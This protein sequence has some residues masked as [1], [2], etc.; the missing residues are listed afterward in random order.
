MNKRNLL[1]ATLGIGLAATSAL[2]ER[3]NMT[4]NASVEASVN[5][6]TQAVDKAG[7][8]VFAVVN[9]SEGSASVGT[10]LR[11][12]TVVIFGSPTIGAAALQTSQTL[13]LYLPLR[14]LFFEDA[15]GQTWL[16]YEDP[17]H[18]AP[19]HG[20]PADNPAVQ[21]MQGALAKF[22]AVAAGG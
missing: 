19:T 4:S 15:L 20:V 14:I 22:A 13:A 18:V 7:A 12:T 9:F 3:I 16:T 1:A 6:L 2:A 8:R 5:R 21:K 17:A 10:A 11:P